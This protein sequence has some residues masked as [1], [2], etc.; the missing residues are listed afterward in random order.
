MANKCLGNYAE[1]LTWLEKGIS[2]SKELALQFGRETHHAIIRDL[3]YHKDGCLA[4]L[5]RKKEA[6]ALYRKI[7]KEARSTSDRPLLGELNNK[8][9]KR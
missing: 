4:G 1:G 9:D 5:N 6:K 3:N 7:E 2:K 8:M